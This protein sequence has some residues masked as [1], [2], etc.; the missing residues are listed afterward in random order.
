MRLALRTPVAAL[1]VLAATSASA[2]IINFSATLE[3][4][5]EVPPN[6]SPA[7]GSA[8]CVMDTDANT[9][10]YTISFSG[11]TATQTAAHFHGFAPAGVNAGVL[12]GLALGSPVIGVWNYMEAQEANIIAGLTYINVHTQAF[13]GGEIR[14]QVLQ[15][16]VGVEPATFS[17]IRSLYR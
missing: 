17:K 11:L 6:A 4:I 8:V 7:T 1:V 9:L 5:Q 3:G 13:P 14:G 16:V 15:D 2:V 10:N 12:H